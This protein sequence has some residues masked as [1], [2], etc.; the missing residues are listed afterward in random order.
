MI[1]DEDS[2]L[3]ITGLHG[4]EQLIKW[5]MDGREYCSRCNKIQNI[6]SEAANELDDAF[7]TGNAVQKRHKCV[8]DTVKIMILT[9]PGKL[10]NYLSTKFQLQMAERSEA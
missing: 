3:K 10:T 7:H 8:V 2:S 5:N 9:L 1:P 6:G 4:L